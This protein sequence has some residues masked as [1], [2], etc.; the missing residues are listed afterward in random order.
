MLG[1]DP[2]ADDAPARLGVGHGQ[3]HVTPW[4]VCQCGQPTGPQHLQRR[5][6]FTEIQDGLQRDN[7]V[8]H[9]G[10][11]VSIAHAAA[12]ED[13]RQMREQQE[14]IDTARGMLHLDALSPT[15]CPIREDDNLARAAARGQGALLDKGPC[16]SR[17]SQDERTLRRVTAH[18]EV[19]LPDDQRFRRHRSTG[20]QHQRRHGEKRQMVHRSPP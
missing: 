11:I 9:H 19:V 17:S 5:R 3:P 2:A 20:S 8:Q 7:L 18:F 16:R 6:G 10:G 4:F 13:E 1:G 15:K 14:A 12:K